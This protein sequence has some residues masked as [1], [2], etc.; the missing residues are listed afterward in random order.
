MP[1]LFCFYGNPFIFIPSSTTCHNSYTAYNMKVRIY[2]ILAL[3]T[4]LFIATTNIASAQVGLSVSPPRVYYSIA[5]GES[6]T[7][8]LLINNIS[9]DHPLDL[10]ITFGDWEY[11]EY[12]NNVM[13][14]PDSLENS[15]ASWLSLPEGTY[16]TLQPGESREV[17][18][19]MNVPRVIPSGDNVQTA[20]LYVTQMN[21]VDGVD[22]QGAAIRINVRQGIKI[23]RKGL[24]GERRALEIT[25]M[26]FNRESKNIVLAFNNNGNIWTDGVIKTTIFNRTTGKETSLSDTPFFTMPGNVRKVM[27]SPGE[28]LEKGE[29]IATVMLDYGDDTILEAAELEFRYD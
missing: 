8:N 5:E 2:I 14:P 9:K 28:T 18:V 16:L 19:M 6:G 7:Q 17:E 22:A 13:F 4:L 29:Y 10:A 12:G 25:D 3:F 27:I 15:C 11:D 20:M 26:T 1:S 24:A 23:Y 21:P